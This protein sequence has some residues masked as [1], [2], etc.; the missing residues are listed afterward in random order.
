MSQTARREAREQ[1]SHL[2]ERLVAEYAGALSA[3]AVIRCVSSAR[4]DLLR[5]GLRNDLIRATEQVARARLSE[6]I[7]AHGMA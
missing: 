7:P 5:A 1:M 2:T 3:G 6:R 4:H